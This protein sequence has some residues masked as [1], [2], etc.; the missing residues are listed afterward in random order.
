MKLSQSPYNIAFSE[1][2][3]LAYYEFEEL[4]SI[5][6]EEIDKE[7]EKRIKETTGMVPMINLDSTKP[8]NI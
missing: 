1:L 7:N 5:I 2:D 4:I 6:N 8:S 3:K